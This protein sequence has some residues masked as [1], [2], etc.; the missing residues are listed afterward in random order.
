MAGTIPAR[1]HAELVIAGAR[2][3]LTCVPKRDDLIGRL[4]GAQIAIGGE[5]IIALGS[6]AELAR[7]VDTT[8]AEVLDVSGKIVAPG[9]VDCHTHLVFGGSRVQEYA[10]RMTMEPSQVRDLGIPSGIRATVAMTRRESVDSLT[11]SATQRVQRMFRHGTTTLESKSGY[12]LSLAEEIKQLEVNQRLQ[13]SQPVDVVSTFLGAHDFPP[14]LRRKEYVELLT[15]EMI[16]KVADLGLAEFCDVY[17]DEG[18]YTAQESRSILEAGLRAGLKPKIHVDAYAD[19][20]GAAVAAELAVVSADHLN[21]TDH[22]ALRR[23]AEAGATGVAMPGLDFAVRH[24]RPVDARAILAEDVTLALATDLCPVCWLE[25]MQVVMQLACRQHRLAPA[26]A[27]YAATSGAARALGLQGDRGSLE[28]GKLAD[29]QVWDLPTFED[30][31]YRLGRNAVTM[32][33][34]RGKVYHF[35]GVT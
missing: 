23:L 6:P 21:Y 10:A 16:P 19:I 13:A 25:S 20:G 15:K 29:I 7:R 34:K 1:P 3:V 2:E 18:Y 12:G 4:P 28:P 5:R 22:L 9:F 33:V 8:A 14:E 30:V 17:C 35:G 26:E 11:A 32:V 24:P 31:V 27:L